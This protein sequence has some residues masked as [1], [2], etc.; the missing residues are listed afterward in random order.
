MNLDGGSANSLIRTD[1]VESRL[2]ERGIPYS[3]IG[4]PPA[5]LAALR[6]DSRRVEPDDLF[7]AIPG[8]AADG[9][10]FV[11]D[12]ATAGAAAAVVERP[13][14]VRIPQLRV[15]DCR[16]AAA[17]LAALFAGDP[18]LGLRLAGVTGTNGKTTT[19]LVLRHLLAGLE[20]AAALGTL[21]LHLP[22]GEVR[23]RGR[24]TT[25]GPVQLN[26]DLAEAAAAGAGW[27]AMEVSSHALDQ[28]RVEGLSFAAAVFTNLSR[29]HLDYHPDMASYRAAKLRFLRHLA[30]DG[31]AVVNADEPAWEGPDFDAVRTV[32]FGTGPGASRASVR[33]EDVRHSARG[34]SWRLVAAGGSAPVELPLLGDFN[35]SNALGAAA[36]AHA[37]GC[38][39]AAIADRLSDAPQIPGRMETLAGPPGPL[40]VRDYAHTPDGLTRALAALRVLAAGRLTVVF[41]CGGDRDRGKRPLMGEAAAT[42]ADRVVVTTDNPRTEPVGRIIDDILRSLPEGAAEVIEDRSD[43]IRDAVERSG[44]GDVVLLAGKG[45]ET[46]QDVQGEKLPFDE[47]AIVAAI[48]G[49]ASGEDG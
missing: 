48:V 16:V 46:Y 33:A 43:A 11:A 20:P 25:P 6:V 15:A 18:A 13:V 27:M 21:G 17:H 8:T 47:A 10:D 7:C 14:D 12:A 19:T 29:E 32:R 22:G 9:H 28:R 38:S 31:V 26:V 4:S 37:L 34:S 41:G 1:R 24:M 42:G 23:P 45:H 49:Q 2:R 40:V 5:N 30:A 36:A 35:V 44:P 39:V 3:W